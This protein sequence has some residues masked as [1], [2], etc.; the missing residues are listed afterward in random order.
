MAQG[1]CHAGALFRP[2]ADRR[3]NPFIMAWPGHRAVRDV[4]A[5][6]WPHRKES[7]ALSEILGPALS[8]DTAWR[9][10]NNNSSLIVF[11]DDQ[12]VNGSIRRR[13]RFRKTSETLAKCR[14]QGVSTEEPP[15]FGP[16]KKKILGEL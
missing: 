15:H 5:R 16:I 12:V 3:S 4:A 2:P 11:M 7:G 9:L 8:G 13:F 14:W 6:A 10:Y 1:G